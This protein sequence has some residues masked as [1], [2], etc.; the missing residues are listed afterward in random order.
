MTYILLLICFMRKDFSEQF[1][2]GETWD[3]RCNEN[4]I[5]M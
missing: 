1:R 2:E 4:Y 5:S 3:A